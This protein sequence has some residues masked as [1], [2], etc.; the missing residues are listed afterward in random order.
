[1]PR[2]ARV[3]VLWNPGTSFHTSVVE[4]LKAAAP[5]LSIELKFVGV[6]R[7]EEIGPAFETAR[8][9]QAQGA[10]RVEDLLFFSHR[11]TLLRFGSNARLPIIY[12]V[13]EFAQAGGLFMGPNYE[14]LMRRSAGY[15][16]KILKGAKSGDLPI[17]Q[18]TKFELVVNLRTAKALGI[19]VPQS[20]LLRADEVIR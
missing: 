17:E 12:P 2:V 7:P 9:A 16:D 11:T 13:K 8:R 4:Q 10:G 18:P 15:V 20:V 5:T 14:D 6:Q 1:M 3:A 19:T